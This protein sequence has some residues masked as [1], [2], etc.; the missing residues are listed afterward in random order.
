MPFDTESNSSTEAKNSNVEELIYDFSSNPITTD[1]TDAAISN[2]DSNN[3]KNSDDIYT[4]NIVNPI[5]DNYSNNIDSINNSKISTDAEIL[6]TADITDSI[7][8]AN[9]GNNNFTINDPIA[10]PESILM[11]ESSSDSNLDSSL[12][13]SNLDNAKSSKPY[14]NINSS[15]DFYN[16]YTNNQPVKSDESNYDNNTSYNQNHN[17]NSTNSSTKNSQSTVNLI[18][19]ICI[20]VV[21]LLIFSP[22]ITGIIGCIIGLFGVAISILVGSIGLLVGGTFTSLVGIPNVPLF[23]ANFPYPVIVLFSLGSISLSLFLT[24]VF[25]YLCKFFIRLLIKSYRALKFK[26]GDL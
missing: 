20:I 3:Y 19:K 2:T 17:Y 26:G 5:N 9:Q 25:Y 13:T 11:A 24:L 1:N 8:N 23:V 21:T 18:L 16:L 6:S 12:D 10:N 4:D 7:D 15:N 22:V 14:E